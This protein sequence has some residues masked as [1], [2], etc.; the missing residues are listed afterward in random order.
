MFSSSP[1][2]LTPSFPSSL[3]QIFTASDTL[4]GGVSL[5]LET[6]ADKGGGGGRYKLESVTVKLRVVQVSTYHVRRSGGAG[7]NNHSHVGEYERIKGG[8]EERGGGGG[9][10]AGWYG[11]TLR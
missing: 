2:L 8:G 1:P 7:N 9:S 3:T 11:S 6:S 5:R 10:S 4:H